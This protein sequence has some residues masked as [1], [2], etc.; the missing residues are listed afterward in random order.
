MRSAQPGPDQCRKS[1]SQ[2]GGRERRRSPATEAGG[3][4]GQG[5]AQWQLDTDGGV[6]VTAGGALVDDEDGLAGLRG[7]PGET[8]ARHDGERG[9]EDQ[10]GFCFVDEAVA[11]LNPRRWHVF[12]E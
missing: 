12:A 2:A 10:Q 7:M 4:I 3:E 11:P 6:G 9:T 8:E 1:C 5:L